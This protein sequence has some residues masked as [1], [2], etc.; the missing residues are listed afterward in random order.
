M[1][2]PNARLASRLREQSDLDEI[3]PGVGHGARGADNRF[4]LHRQIADDRTDRP[5]SGDAGDRRLHRFF[6]ERAECAFGGVLQVDDVG[7]MRERDLR[8]LGAG[9][10]GQEQRH[11]RAPLPP[12]S[13]RLRTSQSS[14]RDQDSSVLPRKSALIWVTR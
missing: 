10:A 1:E 5:L 2:C 13:M 6:G 7:A 12:A 8:F 4:D 14:A 9:H 11:G 3:D